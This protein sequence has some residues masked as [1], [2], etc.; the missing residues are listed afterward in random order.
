MMKNLEEVYLKSKKSSIKSSTLL[1]DHH[2]AFFHMCP[3]T[4]RCRKHSPAKY[5]V[6]TRMKDHP[7]PCEA[8][9]DYGHACE[10]PPW[11]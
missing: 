3:T 1:T 8:H 11:I 4:N 5:F 6:C 7:G 9:F 2:K 10:I